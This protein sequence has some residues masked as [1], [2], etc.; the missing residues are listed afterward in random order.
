MKISIYST[1]LLLIF[2]YLLRGQFVPFSFSMPYE[3]VQESAVGDIDGD[4]DM[5]IF[6]AHIGHKWME[7]VDIVQ[8]VWVIHDLPG[9]GR[10]ELGLIDVDF[11]G[12]LDFVTHGSGKLSYV[13][14][15]D[16]TGT[17]FNSH[18]AFEFTITNTWA[19]TGLADLDGDGDLDFIG[20]GVR[21]AENID[22][23]FAFGNERSI[24]PVP[25]EHSVSFDMNFVDWDQDS[26]TDII[27]NVEVAAGVNQIKLIKNLGLGTFENP[28]VLVDSFPSWDRAYTRVIDVD[29][30]MDFDVVV[31][32]GPEDI[33]WF[34]NNNGSFG[35]SIF[36]HE[37]SDA[38]SDLEIVDINN[39]GLLD[40]S[41]CGHGGAFYKINQGEFTFET[42]S[43]FIGPDEANKATNEI[44]FA[45]LDEDGDLDLL[46]MGISIS[47]FPQRYQWYENTFPNILST[48]DQA[49]FP[50]SSFPNP[51]SDFLTINGDFDYVEVYNFQ[52]LFLFNSSE[53]IL[54]LAS[55]PSG[56]YLLKITSQQGDW[57]LQKIM[58]SE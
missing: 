31:H 50:I 16:G 22:G 3:G 43:V 11:D 41:W 5:D 55:Y 44:T 29:D 18:I 2:P 15:V 47:G 52:G 33:V 32:N 28:I 6:F 37:Y 1:L 54:D 56:L 49:T 13:E 40:V 51:V 57:V 9:G 58:K 17:A 45:D 25:S 30:D 53:H 34:K 19:T 48:D 12:D 38:P 42:E 35:S 36:I 21:W 27:I 24:Y 20:D 7:Q 39:D 26:D 8:N 4:G 46:R 10:G 14:N 23:K